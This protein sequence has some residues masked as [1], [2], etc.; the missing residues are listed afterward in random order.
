MCHIFYFYSSITF[1]TKNKE[2]GP[3]KN[4]APDPPG[5]PETVYFT[6]QEEEYNPTDTTTNTPIEC[7]SLPNVLSPHL[8]LQGVHS[9][10]SCLCMPNPD[11]IIKKKIHRCSVFTSIGTIKKHLLDEIISAA[12]LL[13]PSIH[14]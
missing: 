5:S 8:G 6:D 2:I 13:Q 14:S 3:S 9:S 12:L 7:P 10:P 1:G 4:G 11:Q